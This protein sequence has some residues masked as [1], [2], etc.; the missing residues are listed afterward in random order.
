M[1][2]NL[3]TQTPNATSARSTKEE[4][5]ENTAQSHKYDRT[6]HRHLRMRGGGDGFAFFWPPL[7]ALFAWPFSCEVDH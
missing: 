3:G 4:L 5:E 7:L 1:T 6:D 2:H